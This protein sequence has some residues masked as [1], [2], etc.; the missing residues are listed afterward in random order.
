LKYQRWFHIFTELFEFPTNFRSSKLYW[1]LIQIINWKMGIDTVHL[2]WKWPLA[3]AQPSYVGWPLPGRCPF[4][5]QGNASTASGRRQSAKSS[6]HRQRGGL[7][8]WQGTD[9]GNSR[10]E[11]LTGTAPQGDTSRSERDGSA[12]SD[13]P[14][15]WRWSG[16]GGAMGQCGARG[17]GG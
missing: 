7:G 14:S 11:E 15:S 10:V 12:R 2:C 13:K 17:R 4:L 8:R 1:N 16:H 9:L 5:R 3:L 6:G